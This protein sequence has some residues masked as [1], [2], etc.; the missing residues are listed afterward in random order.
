MQASLELRVRPKD[1]FG[2]CTDKQ[3]KI[4]NICIKQKDKANSG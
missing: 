2:A 3:T 4:E 1:S